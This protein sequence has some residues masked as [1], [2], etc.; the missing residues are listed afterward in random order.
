M[1]SA[2]KEA[3]IPMP[4]FTM[5]VVTKRINTRI[6]EIRGQGRYENPLPGT[7]VDDR[8][9]CPEKYDFYLIPQTARQGTVSPVSFNVLYDDSGLDADKMQRYTYKLCHLYYNWSGTVAVPAPCQ[10]AHKLAFLTGTALQAG[11][12]ERLCNFLHFL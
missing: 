4:K 8:I 2:Y 11:V 7:I 9:T 6:F 1:E 12:N 5:V 3:S 10:Y